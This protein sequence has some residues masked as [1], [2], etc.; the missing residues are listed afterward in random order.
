MV[1]LR[2]LICVAFAV[3]YAGAAVFSSADVLYN[4]S[5]PISTV[6]AVVAGVTILL[7][8]GAAVAIQRSKLTYK[9][10]SLI[11]VAL[12]L[13]AIEVPLQDGAQSHVKAAYASNWQRIK[14]GLRITELDDQPL[15]TASGG[16][17]GVRLVLTLE[18]A[19][20][21]NIAFFPYAEEP[22][23]HSM[24]FL[25]VRQTRDPPFDPESNLFRGGQAYRLSYDLAPSILEW[26]QDQARFCLLYR[27]DSAFFPLKSDLGPTP[28]ELKM[29]GVLFEGTP[30]VWDFDTTTR[31]A[32]DLTVFAESALAADFP[33]CDPASD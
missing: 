3:L 18:S 17:I 13:L 14:E 23:T 30:Q 31:N 19:E 1:L 9:T 5:A 11:G 22:G 27:I 33:D 6:A 8:I 7:L 28:L 21:A 26:D 16:P 10:T 12:L 4:L 2:I 25:P 20:D 24:S 29:G 15:L 32:Y